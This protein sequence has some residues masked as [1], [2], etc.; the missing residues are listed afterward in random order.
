MVEVSQQGTQTGERKARSVREA[1]PCFTC[2]FRGH[3]A[4]TCP[5]FEALVKL[6]PSLPKLA[7]S[8]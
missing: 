6:S 2:N 5:V 4:S 8:V 1:I 7:E 3:I